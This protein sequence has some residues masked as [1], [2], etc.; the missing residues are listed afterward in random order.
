MNAST[1]QGAQNRWPELPYEAWS[2]TLA[3]LHLWLQ[4][5]GKILVAQCAWT[6]HSWHVT[7]RGLG[8]RLMPHRAGAFQMEFDFV[9]HAL[10]IRV[11]DGRAIALPL[12]PHTTAAF[13]SNVMLALG[14]LGID[15]EIRTLPNELTKPIPFELDEVHRSYD[16][17]AVNR[18]WRVLAQTA[19]V[20]E[21]FRARFV[22]KSSPV[23]FFWGGADL[24]VTRFSGRVAPSHPGGIPNLPDW[25][26]RE[27]YSHEVSSAGFW[28]GNEQYPHAAF[29]SYAYPEHEAFPE[30]RVRPSKA[31]YDMTLREFIFPYE[32]MRTAASPEA[33][34]LDFLQSSYDAASKLGHWDRSALE[35]DH[36]SFRNL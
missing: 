34:L 28:A 9:N 14:Q 24:A 32:L 36:L 27:A 29:Y 23:H 15:I 19:V 3:T 6:N 5:V 18:Y 11:I 22:G 25:V 30:A 33:E 13:Y 31:R 10:E 4:I 26:T 7:G 8:T 16:R 12:Y 35:R 20:F 1:T 17:D 21:Q 2:D